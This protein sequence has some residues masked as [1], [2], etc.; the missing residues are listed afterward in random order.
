MKL[1]AWNLNH[2]AARR[3][4]PSWIATA[5]NEQAPDVLVLTEYVEGR[6]HESFL[7]SLRDSRLCTFSCSEQRGRQNQLLIASSYAQRR[8]G[9]V[10]PDIYPSVPSNV[11]E[12]S[13]VSPDVTVLGFRMPAFKGR[14]RALKRPTWNWLLGEAERLRSASA[15]IVGDFNTASGDSKAKCG[16]CLDKL[17]QCGWQHARPA[18][19]YSWRHPR[20][21][22]K[23][24]IDHIFLSP[25][26]VPTQVEYSWEFERLVPEGTSGKAGCPDHAM[27]VCEFELAPGSIS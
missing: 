5:I 19:G 1:L 7:G 2:R 18:S 8:Y 25:S 3:R 24:E 22:T 26:L 12:V 15:L 17:V 9:L 20:F 21:K 16:D 23:R 11:L 13:L 27:L 4:I 6:D 10:T 14:D